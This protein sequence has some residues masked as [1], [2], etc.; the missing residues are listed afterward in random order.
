VFFQHDAVDAV[1]MKDVRE[2]K[3]CGPPADD[4]YLGLHALSPLRAKPAI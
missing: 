3:S 4:G 2:Q 1:A